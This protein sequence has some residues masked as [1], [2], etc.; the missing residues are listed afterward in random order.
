MRSNVRLAT[1]CL[2]ALLVFLASNTAFA[3]GGG[4]GDY[5]VKALGLVATIVVTVL[6]T[7]TARRALKEATDESDGG[8]G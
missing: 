1:A 4:A 5:V 3:A 8:E 6:I 7:R 2:S